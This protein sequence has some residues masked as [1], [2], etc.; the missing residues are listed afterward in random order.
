MDKILDSN[1]NPF[2]KP[3]S[4]RVQVSDN[5]M[6]G[7]KKN[8]PGMPPEN[9]SS[10][11]DISNAQPPRDN[12]KHNC[13]AQESTYGREHNYITRS[14]K[15]PC[16]DEKAMLEMSVR[17][18]E[19]S[20]GKIEDHLVNDTCPKSLRYIAWAKIRPDPDFKTDIKRI[21]KEA[22]RKMELRFNLT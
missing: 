21:R 7:G 15:C 1:G 18:S 19:V 6:S 14:S 5:D 20:L 12:C 16:S 10:E 22:E 3:S 9:Q 13:D 4:T 2:N 11:D 17:K 8:V